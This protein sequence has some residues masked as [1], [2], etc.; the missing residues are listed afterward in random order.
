MK[1]AVVGAA[2]KMALAAVR[3]FIESADVEKVY[4]I[5]QRKLALER[6]LI[7]LASHKLLGQAMDVRDRRALVDFLDGC[8]VCLNASLHY[9]NQDVMLACLETGSHY[10]DLG[11]LFHWARRQGDLHD[12]FEMAGLTAVV[13]AGSA[14]GLTNLMA[15]YAYD[16]LETVETVRISDGIVSLRPISQG[17]APPYAMDTLLDEFC[18]NPYTFQDG[19]FVEGEPFSGQ[20]IIEFPEPVGT[21]TAYSTLHTE[22]ATIPVSFQPKGIR[23]VSFKLSLPKDFEGKLRLLCELGLG[24]EELLSI[25]GQM[26]APRRVLLKLVEEYQSSRAP[27]VRADIGDDHKV[28]RVETAGRKDGR[29]MEYVMECILHPYEK[30]R[31]P[32]G[33]FSVGYPAAVVTKMLGRGEIRRRGVLPAELAVPPEAFFGEM[34]TR[35]I[36]VTANLKQNVV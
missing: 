32:M 15:R 3:E 26:V 35:G 34:K 11:G 7:E 14:P 22:V 30:W 31:M 27:G 29:P 18:M 28:L 36:K 24:G 6:R 4:L 23:N 8:D 5:D 16:R 17:F 12:R 13:G 19:E 1:I 20:E 21:Q 10:V 25:D 2:G 33:V 9:V